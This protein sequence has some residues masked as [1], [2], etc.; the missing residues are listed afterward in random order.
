MYEDKKNYQE[1]IGSYG[2]L[3][4]KFFLPLKYI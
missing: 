3:Q 2:E 4:I 1:F